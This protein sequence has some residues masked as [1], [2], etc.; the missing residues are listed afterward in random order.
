MTQYPRTERPP[1]IEETTTSQAPSRAPSKAPTPAPPR[2][3]CD[4][5]GLHAALEHYTLSLDTN[6]RLC[7]VRRTLAPFESVAHIEAC[8]NAVER[9][10]LQ[11]PRHAYS[12]LV[13]AR[14]GPGR[15]DPTFEEAVKKARG[16][17]LLGFA[18]N[19]ALASTAAGRLQIQRY[20]KVDGRVV[21]ATDDPAAAFEYL[22]LPNHGL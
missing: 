19:A 17:L 9:A 10:L 8:F 14:G 6:C 5:L 4:L 13:D 22:G 2:P 18:R 3:S 11:V 20:A 12:L 21:F 7:F 16:K 15:N 1:R